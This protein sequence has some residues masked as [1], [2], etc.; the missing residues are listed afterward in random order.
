MEEEGRVSSDTSG[1][2]RP[3]VSSDSSE[4]H[5]MRHRRPR[6]SK[7][8]KR[9]RRS[10]KD[11]GPVFSVARTLLVLAVV[12]AGIYIGVNSFDGPAGAF[13]GAPPATESSPRV[14]PS[15]HEPVSPRPVPS[16]VP[17]QSVH[18]PPPAIVAPIV[19]EIRP[20][21]PLCPKRSGL[22]PVADLATRRGEAVVVSKGTV[23]CRC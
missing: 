21:P 3:D 20:P 8:G 4:E 9:K 18:S 23:C 5:H 1:T 22:G 7:R 14:P 19:E 16:S 12:V 11:T 15:Q 13:G 10:S 2:S 17:P 6:R